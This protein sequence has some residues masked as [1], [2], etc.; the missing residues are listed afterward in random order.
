[1]SS[2][3]CGPVGDSPR[4]HSGDERFAAAIAA[5]GVG[6]T[7]LRRL[8]AG[9]GPRQAWE[10]IVERRHAVDLN[11]ELA[12][13]ARKEWPDV[14]AA[15]LERC[16][17]RVLLR[18]RPGYPEAILDDVDSPEILFCLGKPEAIVGRPR[19]AVVGT[20]SATRYGADV[21]SDLGA[22]LAASD[23]V[24]VSGLATGIDAAAHAGVVSVAGGAPPVAVIATGIDIAYPRS[25]AV[26]R[27]SVAATG[28]VMSELPPGEP[29]ERWR[30]ADRN[31]IMA[32]LAH[33]VVVVECHRSGGALYT[34]RAA[35]QRGREV[36]AVPGSVRSAASAGT[37]AL[38]A[39]G[40][41]P[42]RD[43]ADVLTAVELA[44]AGDGSVKPPNWPKPD[45]KVRLSGRP[46]PSGLSARVYDVIESEPASLEQVVGRCGSTLGEVAASL[47]HLSELGLVEG[48]RGWWRRKGRR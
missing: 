22:G 17:A 28:A 32:A 27:D 46:K 1:M 14:Y 47:E 40:V 35:K 23:V 48:E 25:N 20:R 29:G 44:I 42:A 41:P 16:G 9:M 31:R 30:F 43:V 15:R 4:T 8:L 13:K 11:G 10:A 37:N 5:L 38:L 2:R 7:T 3:I 6:R 33:V 34:V 21:A 19:V 18:G 39:D 12:S 24:V 45:K 36:M 26:L